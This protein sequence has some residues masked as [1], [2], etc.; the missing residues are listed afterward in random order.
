MSLSAREV[1]L[2]V[3][4][5]GYQFHWD[6][7]RRLVHASFFDSDGMAW[8]TR[9]WHLSEYATES[10]V[11]HTLLLLVLTSVEHETREQFLFDGHPIFHPHH[12]LEDLILTSGRT[13]ARPHTHK[14][15]A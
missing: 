4:F 12:R 10:E 11:V 5:P 3:S 13:D 7:A 9:K 15:A 1:I 2:R 8:T 6:E 14:E